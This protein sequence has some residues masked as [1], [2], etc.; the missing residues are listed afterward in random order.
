[1]V[2]ALLEVVLENLVSLLRNEFSTISRIKSKAQNLSNILELI[3]AVLEDAE[4]KQ[5]KDSSI[6]VWLQQLKDAVY[7]LDDMLD[8]CSIQSNRLKGASSLKPKNIMFRYNIG[9]K[10]KEITKRFDQIAE[11]KN[12]FVLRVGVNV[13][14]WPIE[15]AEWRQTSSTIAGPKVYGREDDK[16]KM[17]KRRLLSFFSPK[18]S[19]NF[20][21]KVWV[22]VSEIFS[23]KR[24]LCSIIESITR[25]K[26]DALDLDVFE[27]K[28]QELLQGK[29]YLLVLDDVWNRNQG[30]EFGLSPEKWNKLKSVLSCGSKGSSILVSTRDK[31]VA[32]IMGTCQ[33]HHLSGLSD[34][35][36]WLLF[37]QYAFGHDKGEQEELEAI[38]KEIVKKCGGLPLAAQALG[39]IMRSRSGEKEWLEVKENRLW[40]LPD[41]NYILPALS[42]S[43]LYLTPTL[44]QCFAFCAMYPKDTEIVKADLIYLW[45][46]NGF[47]SSRKN[48]DVEDVGNMIWNELCQKS[49]FQDIKMNDYSADICFKM[50][51]LVHDLA[52]SVMG[53][54]CLFL[55]NGDVTGL[56]KSTHHISFKPA[57]MLSFDGDA[58][59][60]VESLRTWYQLN[61]YNPKLFTYFPTSRSLRVLCTSSFKLS[62]CGSLIHLRY[63]E[64][65]DFD[66]IETIPDSIYNLQKLEI[67]KLKC[68]L[69]LSC[70]PKHLTRLKYLR[71]LIIQNCLSLSRVSPFIGK[72]SCL[73]TLSVYIVGLETGHNLRELH[74]LKLGGKLSIE[75]LKNVISLSDAQ[76]ANLMGKTDLQVLCLSWGNSGETKTPIISPKQVLEVLQ[77]HSNVKS[78]TICFYDGLFFPTWIG[79]LSSL[80]SLVFRCCT[81]CIRLPPI[82]NLPF[83]KNLELFNM[84]NL[85]YMDDDDSL[86]GEVRAFPSLEKLSLH[87]L[88]NLE[89]LLKV[90]RKEMFPRL[91][92][93]TINCCPKLALPCLPSAKYL[94]VFGC[95]NEML[96]SISSFC[97]LTTL[98]L[99]ANEDMT[100]FR[101]GILRNMTCL[102][103]LKIIGFT[104]LKEFPNDFF[105]PA[106]EHLQ[107]SYCG[108]L[109]SLPE[110]IWEG[111][112]SLRTLKIDLCVRLRSLPE[113]IRHLTS[114]EVLH[115]RGCP[116]LK[117]RCKE[118]IGKDWDK[119]AHIPNLNID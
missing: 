65:Y 23:V 105:N 62:S 2:E 70:L 36:C 5:V 49:F 63:L 68:F 111:L 10:F 69:K 67:L 1:M 17:I 55:E 71:H 112:R 22:C 12:K 38:G 52:Q 24:I 19:S 56:S 7:V 94:F 42:L 14:E 13:R 89:R 73:R 39:G 41:Q 97:G 107:I 4:Q 51:D 32:A 72:L 58:F 101:E 106:L 90:D 8:E 119:I 27:R 100:S 115:I 45:M 109:E 74:D 93:L 76:D 113:S 108:K 20:H 87:R 110:K 104:E 99:D 117:E 40:S 114:L 34:N 47:I 33:F 92:N 64:L 25:E 15:V 79:I 21:T 91:S 50:H 80:V 29:R 116:I 77:P 28:V 61:F 60:K 103:T 11:S 35:E 44:K 82:G 81:N 59:K 53:S 118:E 86:N 95:N 102:H 46:S 18:V 16:E 96:S 31:D 48:L 57:G 43:Y 98:Q 6:K 78:L 84:D 54:E 26:C 3:N 85:Q 66:G 30:L 37:K 9:N 83:L 75:G 88:P